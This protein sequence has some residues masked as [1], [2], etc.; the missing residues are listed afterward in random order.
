MGF[1]WV[2]FTFWD[3]FGYRLGGVKVGLLWTVVEFWVDFG[4]E[5][6]CVKLGLARV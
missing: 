5:L 1:V 3:W 6:D 2:L 4:N